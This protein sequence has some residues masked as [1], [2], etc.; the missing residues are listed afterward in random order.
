MTKPLMSYVNNKSVRPSTQSDQLLCSLLDSIIPKDAI[1]KILRL[2]ISEAD[3][4]GLSLHWS[5]N[6]N[7]KFSYDVAHVILPGCL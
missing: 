2:A 1:F 7:S 5:H 3:Q 6:S 4:A